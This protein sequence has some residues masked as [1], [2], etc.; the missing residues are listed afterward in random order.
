MKI[1]RKDLKLLENISKE[2][3]E[4]N[5]KFRKITDDTIEQIINRSDLL[6]N[7]LSKVFSVYEE[8]KEISAK[9]VENIDHL[10]TTKFVKRLLKI[11]LEISDYAILDEEVKIE[12]IK[13]IISDVSKY[14]MTEDLV[15]QYLDEIGSIPLLDPEE[16]VSLFVEYG[17]DNDKKIIKKICESNLRLVVSIAKKYVGKGLDLLDLIQEGNLGLI[18]A[19]EKYDVTR[20]YKLSTYATYWIKQAIIRAIDDKGRTI[21]IP[22]HMVE[23]IN[24]I[25]RIRLNYET[26]HDG[27]IPSIEKLSELSGLP[28]ELVKKCLKY[29]SNVISLDMPVGEDSHGVQT[30]LLD[31]T[32][33]DD[34]II[35]ETCDRIELK[36]SIQEVLKCIKNEREVEIIS[37]RFG[38]Y[39]GVPRTLEEVGQ[40][41][42]IT[43][44]R[45][46]QIEGKILRKIRSS[47]SV[48]KLK[49]FANMD[50]TQLLRYEHRKKEEEKNLQSKKLKRRK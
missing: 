9:E 49:D 37:L 21:R 47:Q 33:T 27:E 32:A 25:K 15:K 11:Y 36:R 50:N 26:Q 8:K 40:K 31:Y 29:E 46:R 5:L 24:K 34:D 13:N 18:K 38:L 16:E 39:D 12:D 42:G 19:V 14:E 7:T 22:V 2:I 45:V 23:S 20:G 4:K 10:K 3:I 6:K 48:L 28:K 30:T 43:R 44:E 35:E 41:Y 17:K 1:L